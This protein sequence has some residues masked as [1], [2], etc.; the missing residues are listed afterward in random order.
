MDIGI[1]LYLVSWLLYLMI[2]VIVLRTIYFYQKTLSPD[3]GL[4]KY[5]RQIGTCR[6]RPTCSEY[7]YQAIEKFG[8]LKGGWLGMKR[9]LRCNPFNAG[10]W[11]PPNC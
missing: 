4:M 9:V 6:F 5:F 1:Y 11:D 7:A 10:G 3:H 2:K 8:V